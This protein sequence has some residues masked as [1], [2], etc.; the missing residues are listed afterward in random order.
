MR[1]RCR[2][3]S[4]LG[5]CVCGLGMRAR[6]FGV[7]LTETG[8][9]FRLWAPAARRV[10]LLLDRPHPMSRG[11]D[12]WFATEVAGVTPGG[13]YKYRIDD[14]VDVPDPASDFQPE[15]VAGP[16]EVID[17]AAYRWRASDW[18]GGGGGGGGGVGNPV[19]AGSP[20]AHPPAPG[21]GGPPPR[22]APAPRG[23]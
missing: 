16:S 10:D 15:D 1:R 8:A 6:Q 3:A 5:S 21:G 11:A 20:P 23:P 13:R 2:G 4:P 18:R 19:W 9:T 17:Q 12:G 22:G 14:E 7:R